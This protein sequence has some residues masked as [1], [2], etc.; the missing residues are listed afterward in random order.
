[1]SPSVKV[2]G[3]S[4]YPRGIL[5]RKY[6]EVETAFYLPPVTETFFLNIGEA[7]LPSA[8]LAAPACIR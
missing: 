1:M 7:A 4:T 6:R 3:L 5:S 8:P 2:K